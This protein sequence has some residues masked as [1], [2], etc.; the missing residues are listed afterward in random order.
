MGC[1][2]YVNSGVT[3]VFIGCPRDATNELSRAWGIAILKPPSWGN[4]WWDVSQ[5]GMMSVAR[6]GSSVGE[7]DRP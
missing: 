4:L 3:Q 2:R 7:R 1:L 6:A 5:T